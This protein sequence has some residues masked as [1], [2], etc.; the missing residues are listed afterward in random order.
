VGLAM[1]AFYDDFAR[2]VAIG[3]GWCVPS[4]ALR[5]EVRTTRVSE[6]FAA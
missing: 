4:M 6:H 1:S 2:F 5:V 3:R